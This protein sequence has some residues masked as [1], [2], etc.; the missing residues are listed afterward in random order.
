MLG[1]EFEPP[2][3]LQWASFGDPFLMILGGVHDHG[4]MKYVD[5]RFFTISGE[6]DRQEH[7]HV[8]D[9]F[10]ESGSRKSMMLSKWNQKQ[11]YFNTSI[12]GCFEHIV[13]VMPEC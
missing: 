12:W 4:I 1:P 8:F 5:V 6:L 10:C 7:R 13:F 2:K 3:G 9:D 11:A